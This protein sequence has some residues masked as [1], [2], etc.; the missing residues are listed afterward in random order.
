LRDPVRRPRS[1]SCAAPSRRRARGP[2]RFVCLITS[3]RQADPVDPA[4]WVR[5]HWHIENKFH[6]VRDVTYQEDKSPGQDRKRAARHG[7]AAQ[8]GDFPEVTVVADAGIIFE[9]NQFQHAS[10]ESRRLK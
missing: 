5:G 7:I 10:P 6:R 4:A 1:R 3:D 2:S 8:P 9:A